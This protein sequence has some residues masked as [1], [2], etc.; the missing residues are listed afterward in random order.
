MSQA[1][2]TADLLVSGSYL[3]LQ[4]KDKTIIKNGAVAIHQG[5]HC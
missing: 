1:G 5:Y 2:H 3:Y 4:N